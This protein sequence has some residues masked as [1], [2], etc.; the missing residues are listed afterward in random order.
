M[1]WRLQTIH[2]CDGENNSMFSNWEECGPRSLTLW[3]CFEVLSIASCKSFIPTDCKSKSLVI[4]WYK[5]SQSRQLFASKFTIL[6]ANLSVNY[7]NIKTIVL[8]TQLWWLTTGG[9]LEKS[10]DGI[11]DIS[12][13]GSVGWQWFP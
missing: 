8:R 3:N 2:T 6:L 7:I 9:L 11:L 4:Y 12:R 5:T 13:V 10:C 1:S